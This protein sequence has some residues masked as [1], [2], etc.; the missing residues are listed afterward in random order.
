MDWYDIQDILFDGTP[1]QIDAVKCPDCGGELRI[2]YFQKTRSMEILCSSCY[3]VIRLNGTARVP[4][5]A[6]ITA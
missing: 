6:K 4:N 1:E 2:S 5:F 3:T